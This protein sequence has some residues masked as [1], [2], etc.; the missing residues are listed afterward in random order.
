MTISFVL[1]DDNILCSL[2]LPDRKGLKECVVEFVPLLD[3]A[4]HEDEND[5]T[6]SDKSNDE[7]DEVGEFE[8]A[9]KEHNSIFGYSKR[10]ACIG[11]YLAC[12]IRKCIDNSKANVTSNPQHIIQSALR[13]VRAINPA[14]GAPLFR[15]RLGARV[16][17][18]THYIL[19]L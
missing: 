6:D 7:A 10:I 13:L 16:T 4:E 14:L 17:Y 2:S 8:N 11:H 15:T 9:E 3:Q 12:V 18:V 19:G 1:S 5:E